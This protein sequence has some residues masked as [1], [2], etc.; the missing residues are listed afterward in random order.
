MVPWHANAEVVGWPAQPMRGTRDVRRHN[1]PAQPTRL[2]G[3]EHDVA[4]VRQVVLDAEGRL[5][6][7]TGAGG[8]GKTRLALQV[9][10]ELTEAFRDGVRLIELAPL[11]D[12]S[13]VA[14]IV[15]TAVGVQERPG[16]PILDTLVASLR[17]RD[18]LLVLDNCEHLVEACGDLANAV[19]SGCPSVRLL[20]T[21]REPLRVRSEI[22]WR[23]PSLAI[24]DLQQ[25]Q[26]FDELAR[27]PAVRL[28]VERAQAVQRDFELTI[29]NALAVAQVCA[30]LE[31]LPL[32]IELAAVRVRA[33]GVEQLRERLGDSFRLL[34]GGSRT[35]PTRQ[36]TLKATLDWSHNLLTESEQVVFRR[37]AVFAGGWSLEAA[38]AVCRGGPVA[39]GDVL[40]VLTQL[41]DKSLVV[42]AERD[43]RARY[44]FLE[45]VRQYAL[46]RLEES[47]DQV[48]GGRQHASF[49]LSFSEQ[50]E[51]DANV[52]GPRRQAAHA[53]LRQE[54]DNVRAALRWCVDNAESDMGIRLGKAHTHFWLF[55]SRYHEGRRW[56]EQVLALPGAAE[57]TAA[58]AAVL[59]V[60]G[61]FASRLGDYA[62]ARPLYEEALP[63]ARRAG[64]PWLLFSTLVD[65]AWD[66]EARG[67]YAAAQPLLD[68]ALVTTRAAGERVSEAMALGRLGWL[69]C[70]QSDYALARARCEE[71]LAVARAAG[72]SHN[73]SVVLNMLGYAVLMQGDVV[74]ARSVLEE[75]L[76]MRRQEGERYGTAWVL[77]GL[78]LVATDDGCYEE[79]WALFA[80]SLRL[81]HQLGDLV[82]T[83]ESL[84]SMGGLAAIQAQP[85]R[86]AQLAGAAAALRE[87]SGAP[88]SPM[89][90]A[91]VNRWLLPLR[92]TVGE[93]SIN[94]AYAAG[95]AT[96][97]DHA[98]ALAL[99]HNDPDQTILAGDLVA[100]DPFN[101]LT[102]RED[103]VLRLVAAGRSN[104]EIADELVLSVRTV[105][106]HITN[107]YAKIGARGKADA[108]AY[109]FRHGLT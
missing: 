60:A 77:D 57:S 5:V 18:L 75:S 106:R 105:E 88:L 17:Q 37:L 39:D 34:V 61:T 76:A 44:R 63:I 51:T 20:A 92:Q 56:L 19:L 1:L 84:E 48:D 71:G 103:E 47:G 74:T 73:V 6:T 96:P 108:T 13:L 98:V 87:I 62:A 29:Q 72:D 109:A 15:A 54:Q 53:A 95:R 8:C 32:A 42:M 66:A 104:R 67:D 11:V 28:F 26:H 7:L 46:A 93:D 78:G 38:E 23:V 82:G 40:E 24:P 31:G 55:Q 9:A 102:A 85:E 33:L 83:A 68:E 64:N 59:I 3:R 10:A 14:Q 45:P 100:E 58:R 41:V 89:R 97:L 107:L 43:G 36:R 52:G 90:R 35:A 12:P 81:R 2:I 16:R 49:F 91:I 80:E 50:W 65:V 94:R 79:A 69:A 4:A 101:P 21:S 27:S 30:Q 25:D 70:Q 86:A 22:T 99:A